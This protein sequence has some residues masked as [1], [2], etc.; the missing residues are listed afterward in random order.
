MDKEGNTIKRLSEKY[1]IIV[2]SDDNPGICFQ[3]GDVI[4]QKARSECFCKMHEAPDDIIAMLSVITDQ[5]LLQKSLFNNLFLRYGF[6]H[7]PK[8]QMTHEIC[9]MLNYC[10]GTNKDIDLPFHFRPS[11]EITSWCSEYQ[12]HFL[13]RKNLSAFLDPLRSKKDSID[14]S[15]KKKRITVFALPNAYSRYKEVFSPDIPVENKI[16]HEM[17][18]GYFLANEIYLEFE[19]HFDDYEERLPNKNANIRPVLFYSRSLIAE[20]A[21]IPFWQIRI[22]AAHS[23]FQ[24]YFECMR[25]FPER[26][27]NQAFIDI[28]VQD[29]QEKALSHISPIISFFQSD[30]FSDWMSLWRY[31][32]ITSSKDDK[33]FLSCLS[34]IISQSEPR[35]HNTEESDTANTERCYT[36]WLKDEV[37]FYSHL[38]RETP[39][40]IL[41]DY[42]FSSSFNGL[43]ESGFGNGSISAFHA[44]RLSVVRSQYKEEFDE[45]HKRIKDYTEKKKE[46][47]V[48]ESRVNHFYAYSIIQCLVTSACLKT[49]HLFDP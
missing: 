42:L 37:P 2:K 29:Y 23:V 8:I 40:N 31:Y 35:F 30:I 20:L 41:S 9:S 6:I 16:L 27:I 14:T 21:Q 45:Y 7:S 46:I 1:G 44:N 48:N 18:F 39:D 47:L 5:G 43:R 25:E 28:I 33:D 24:R 11:E 38:L 13:N 34:Q 22:I 19:Q 12:K 36:M 10:L 49:F 32:F 26:H 17:T 4:L 15:S 3:N